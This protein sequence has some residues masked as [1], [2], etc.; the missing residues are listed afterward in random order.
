M[1]ILISMV[2]SR[3]VAGFDR[4]RQEPKDSRLTTSE[5][6]IPKEW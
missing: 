1:L 5:R 6:R 4:D 2:W 3:A